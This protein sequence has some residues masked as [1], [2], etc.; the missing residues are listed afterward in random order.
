[1]R[2]IILTMSLGLLASSWINAQ[3]L[4]S[5]TIG[6]NPSGAM[7]VVDGTIY[8]TPQVFEW[9]S[10]S[11]HIVQFPFS[12]D[13][14]GNLLN[15]Q[16]NNNNN[17]HYF[18]GAWVDNNALITPSSSS[19]ITVTASPSLTSL[20]GSVTVQYLVDVV[21]NNGTATE[22]TNCSGAAAPPTQNQ[23]LF[24]IV[25]VASNCL[26]SSAEL[27]LPAGP[28]TLNAY[29]YPGWVFYGWNIN[30]YQPAS[31]LFSY[32]LTGPATITPLFSLAK[33][34]N[35]L[36]NPPSLQVLVDRTPIQTPAALPASTN[37]C[38]PDFPLSPAGAPAGF[39]TLCLGQFDFLPGSKHQLGAP[40]P[41]QDNAGN[42]WVFSG[43]SDGLGQNSVYTAD[44]NTNASDTVTANFVAG[45][46]V[47]I[48][49][50]PGGLQITVDG[51]INFPPPYNYVWGTGQ[52][53]TITAPAQQTDSH[54]RVWVF[55]S[56]SNGGAASQTVTVPASGSLVMNATYTELGQAQV[57]SYPAGLTFTINGNT[58]T[59]PCILNQSNG[60]QVQIT[61]P[62]SVP[63]GT[64]TRY[65]F[66]SWSDGSTATSRQ[67]SFNQGTLSLTANYQTSYL[68]TVSPNPANSATF[69]IS[70]TSPDGFYFTGTQ[71]AVTVTPNSGYKF[72]KWEVSLSS[73][74]TFTTTMTSPQSL[75]AD[76]LSVPSISAAGIETAAGP[77]PD[78]TVAAGSLI[79]IYGQGLAPAM[80]VGPTNPLAQAIGNVT[81]TVNNQLLPLVFVSPG[82]IAAQVP[83]ELQPGNYTL[84]VHSVGQPDVSGQMTVSRDAP[85]LF[86]LPN[87]Q[88]LPLVLALHQ[89]GTVIDVN[90]PALHN[91][92]IS[93]YGTG[94]G[95]FTGPL[96]DGFPVPPT[97]N[98]QATDPVTVTCGSAQVEPDS[99]IPAPGMVGMTIVKLTISNAI[100]SATTAN[101]TVTV[102]G[103]I[104]S[105]VS[106][107]LQ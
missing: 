79:A 91:E 21:F 76:L 5:I 23:L 97:E 47:S 51:N 49:T 70:P 56:W 71:V 60:S 74:A 46:P 62:S 57:T 93:I 69:S 15:Y 87:T 32:N 86:Q 78:G 12:A 18:F 30:G 25:Y 72:S 84:V 105:V 92:Q 52:T 100:P 34:V 103:K 42:W 98:V 28:I 55:S 19:T 77:T 89:D 83:W 85:A 43:F 3:T 14:Y 44:T 63:S 27:F 35:F 2:R 64:N 73:Y 65:D 17:T 102:N 16:S 90:H 67:V 68:L 88:N 96:S 82:Q 106:L 26:A 24:G 107:P 75:I 104:S 95:P 54:G 29:P 13:Q 31:A 58:C 81:V 8:L 99:V 59:T 1:M 48:T 4:T 7:F 101:L 80:Q 66:Q 6:L 10:G 36:T 45:I 50:S 20:T 9:P 37:G 94:F 22:T 33:L 38:S 40:T 39:P 41:Q 61:I 11:E 53:H